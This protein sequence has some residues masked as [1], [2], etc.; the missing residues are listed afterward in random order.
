M[1]P[2]DDC[3]KVAYFVEKIPNLSKG[4]IRR[5]F[6]GAGLIAE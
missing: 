1:I 3:E 6:I 4:E 5:L 2:P